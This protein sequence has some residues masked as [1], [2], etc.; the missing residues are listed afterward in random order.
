M[1]LLLSKKAV[2]GSLW[3]PQNRLARVSGLQKYWFGW[4]VQVV[5]LVRKGRAP[6]ASDFLPEPHSRGLIGAGYCVCVRLRVLCMC[7]AQGLGAGITGCYTTPLA[8][9]LQLLAV[10]YAC[11]VAYVH[12]ALDHQLKNGLASGV[13][14][15]R[16]AH[17]GGCPDGR[18]PHGWDE[19]GKAARAGMHRKVGEV[20]N[21]GRPAYAQPLSPRRQVPAP[22]AFVT[23]SNSPQPK[24]NLLQPPV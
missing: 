8:S 19:G 9:G 10:K 18:Q 1:L 17:C 12:R 2:N 23:D 16:C 6:L 20:P 4:T 5:V 11:H 13:H 3:Q 7:E 21:P 24:R 15:N 14:P 22:T